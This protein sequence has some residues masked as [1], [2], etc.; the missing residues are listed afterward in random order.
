ML[1]N[2]Q[3]KTLKKVQTGGGG[4]APGARAR[5]PPL[6][7]KQMGIPSLFFAINTL[8]FSLEHKRTLGDH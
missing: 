8:S 5:D 7:N 4:G 3:S 1:S 6:F 2:F